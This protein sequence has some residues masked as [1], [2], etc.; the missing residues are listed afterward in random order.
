[1]LQLTLRDIINKYDLQSDI[2]LF[3]FNSCQKYQI[4]SLYDE[5]R[6]WNEWRQLSSYFRTLGVKYSVFQS[7]PITINFFMWIE[8][9]ASISFESYVYKSLTNYVSWLSYYNICMS[10]E[11]HGNIF[12]FRKVDLI[13]KLNSAS[14]I[15]I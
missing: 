3:L 9:I 1:M 8:I 5:G 6:K 13:P 15:E 11:I 10:L 7:C 12:C 4:F 14:S 2:L